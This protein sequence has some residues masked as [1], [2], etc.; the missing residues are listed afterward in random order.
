MPLLGNASSL[1]K[2]PHGRGL[3][4]NI[5][6]YIYIYSSALMVEGFLVSHGRDEISSPKAR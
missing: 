2:I 6:I 3:S 4:E 5:Y 1:V